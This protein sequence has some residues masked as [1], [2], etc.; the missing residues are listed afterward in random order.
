MTDD[1]KREVRVR[2]QID[3][4]DAEAEFSHIKEEAKQIADKIRAVSDK[5]VAN[6]RLEPSRDDFD[7]NQELR[8]RLSPD[9]QGH[10]NFNEVIRVIAELRQSRQKVFNLR[11]RKS[12]LAP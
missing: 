1:A 6:T 8:H 9:Q 7:L 2:L 11:E 4:E 10:L 3:L 12:Q 5:I